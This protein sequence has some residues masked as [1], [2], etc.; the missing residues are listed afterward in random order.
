MTC[1]GNS[2]DSPCCWVDGELCVHLVLGPHPDGRR[3]A[4]G[5][6]IELGSWDAVHADERY[7]HVHAAW[8]TAGVPDCGDWVGP[9]CC[10][11]R[12]ETAES[13]H[14]YLMAAERPGTPVEIRRARGLEPPEETETVTDQPPIPRSE[15]PRVPLGKRPKR[16]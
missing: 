16:P 3:A 5:L 15:K 14:S 6:F 10:Y 1:H 12:E 13:K 8:I 2:P 11:G 9:G 7:E 4:C